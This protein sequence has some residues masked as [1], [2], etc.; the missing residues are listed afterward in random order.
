M[1]FIQKLLARAQ[2]LR[3]EAGS[4]TPMTIMVVGMH[5]SGT[6]FLTGS[7]QQAG[8]ELGKHSAWNPHNLKGNRENQDIVAFHDEVLAARGCA[9]DNPPPTQIIWTVEERRRAEALMDGYRDVPRWGFK[10]P[11]ALLMV[12]GWQ[13]LLPELRFVGIFR[14]PTAVAQSLAA[15][16]GMSEVQALALWQA[17]NLRLLRLY[18]QA[19]FPLLCFDEDEAQLHEKLD[20]VLLET[21]LEPLLGERFFSAELKHHVRVEQP[22]PQ[23]VDAIYQELRACA[24]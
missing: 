10:D 12:E 9:W 11:R 8:L 14:H 16:G 15:R 23:D 4:S 7:L 6:S 17:Y 2:S 3:G 18:Q 5:R 22:L 19:A 21:G 24:R 20:A 1:R 13:Q